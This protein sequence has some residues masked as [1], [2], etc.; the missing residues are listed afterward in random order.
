MRSYA[1]CTIVAALLF[2]A[3]DVAHAN[4]R[5]PG[6][7]GL[8]I[9][10][11]DGNELLLGLTYGLALTLD[12]GA[13]WS[14]MC[15]QQIDGNGGNVDPSIVVTG[16]GSI[17]VLS[18]TN[19]GVLVSQD[20]GCTFVR[21]QGQLERNRGV[22]LT[23]DPSQPDHVYALLS[24]IMNAVDGG[25]P[26]YRNVLAHSID[27]GGSW[28]VLAELPEDLSAETVEVA[29]SDPKR[30][31]VSGTASSDPLQGVVERSDDGGLTWKRTTVQLPRGSGSLYLSAIHPSDPDRLWF[32]VPG[33]GD[34]YGVLPAKLWLSMDG[35]ASFAPLGE[36]KAGMLGLALSPSG[37]RIAFG[38]PSDGLFVAPADASAAPS[39]VSDL[40]VSCLRWRANGLYLCSLEPLAPFSLGFAAEPT[41]DFVPLW[42]RSNT[43]RAAC[44][45]PSPLEMKCRQPWEMIAP[46]VD[47][48]TPVCGS[49]ASIPD[50]GVDAGSRAAGGRL[51]N[52]SMAGSRLDGGGSVVDASQV[53]PAHTQ[54]VRSST[55]GGCA[56]VS[57]LIVSRQC[58]KCWLA[59]LLTLMVIAM[60]RRRGT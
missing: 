51:D 20:H 11:S 47:A 55:S 6:A 29:P 15:E 28:T 60:L 23:L 46:F 1:S 36:T 57:P 21:P 4:G 48:S 59:P 24:T 13:S 56:V 30:I 8:A 31:Y 41:Q 35:G 50:A 39:K 5:L 53:T 40:P 3:S 42:K 10:P 44:A 49:S 27:N 19:G 22:D 16:N 52:G 58:P 33:R 32:R 14:W 37:D 45:P 18:L 38:G 25:Y 12:G 9:G 7:T 54:S 26:T 17:V 43:C 34:I 2:F